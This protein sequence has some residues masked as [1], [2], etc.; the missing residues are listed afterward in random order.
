MKII[1]RLETLRRLN[2]NPQWVNDNIFRL[3][4]SPQLAVLAY[5]RIKSN[6]GNMTVGDD[7]VTLDHVS[8]GFL[9]KLC[10]SLKDGSYNPRPIRR[11]LIPK[12]NGKTRPLGI[13]SPR[14]KIVQE[15]V[16]EILES[17]YDSAEG[18]TFSPHSHGFRPNLSCHTAVDE[19]TRWHGVTW[20]VEGDI[21]GFFDNIDHHCLINLLRRRIKDERLINLIWK[22]LRVEIR[23]ENGRLSPNRRGTPQGGV[24]SPI[25][26]NIYL[27]EF[28]TWVENL[29]KELHKGDRRKPNPEWRKLNRR[30]EYL[31][32][33]GQ[34]TKDS[35]VVKELE[36]QAAMLPTVMTN[37]PDFCRIYYVRYADDWIIGV[38][39]PKE[40]AESVKDKAASF[41]AQNLKLELSEEK[42]LITHAKTKEANFLGFRLYVDSSVKRAKVKTEGKR[43]TLK[44]VTGWLPRVSVPARDIVAKLDTLGFCHTAKGRVHFP[45]SRNTFVALEDHEI[46]MRFNSVWRGIY[47]YYAGCHNSF[48]L[49][50]AMYIL[51]YSCLM[52]LSHKHRA[53]LPATIRKYGKF[54][55]TSYRVASGEVREVTFWKPDSWQKKPTP[56]PRPLDIEILVA[57]TKRLT[58]SRLGSPCTVCGST[59]G[60]EMHH[61]R[62]LRKGNKSITRGFN[63][64]MSAINRKQVPVCDP[65][66]HAIHRGDYDDIKLSDLAYIPQ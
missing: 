19:F 5:E 9:E 66:H 43:T 4:C 37:D 11:K 45:R 44:R 18:P 21:K 17:I 55:T 41:L 62:A 27:H 33:K 2:R 63:R 26:A 7:G 20:L 65:C 56:S 60:V 47:N 32:S 53:K 13:P 46:I 16:R 48:K 40:L 6:P 39:G 14:D 22:F 57:K 29:Q 10:E 58:R 23:E 25:L 1:E 51:Q 64:V 54:P 38:V 8:L 30:R 34:A 52:T 15:M 49:N 61:I 50:R 28:D 12:P 42:T 3:V 31:L 24:V 35:E 36:R 59:K